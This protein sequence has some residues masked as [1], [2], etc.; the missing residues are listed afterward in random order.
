MKTNRTY[1][2][3]SQYALWK[4][5][6]KGFYKKYSQ[7]NSVPSTKFQDFGKKFMEDLEFGRPIDLPQ[8]SL[9]RLD[10]LSEVEAELTT[11]S[12]FSLLGII[13][14]LSSNGTEFR[15]YKTGKERWT[16]LQVRRDEQTL[17]YAYLIYKNFNV[18]PT[19][20]LIWIETAQTDEEEIFF[21]GN[22]TTFERTFTLEEI[23]EMEESIRIVLCE[24]EE[25]EHIEL[26]IDQDVT[27]KLARLVELQ[28]KTDKEITLIKEDILSDLKSKGLKYGDGGFGTYT[29]SIRKSYIFSDQI[30]DIEDNHK[31]I[32]S[33][34]KS[35]EIK[36][37]IAI[38]KETHSLLFKPKKF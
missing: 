28:K 21:T 18:I 22:I 38:P 31:A 1:L 14:S 30:I 20:K 25:Y 24:I 23:L 6:Q 10:V 29:I 7:N 26:D 35:E 37:G 17:F 13:D 3:Y 36:K 5:S 27:K 2:S 15:E 33:V 9:E 11:F 32:L 34:S 19:A 4:S 8:E 12:P 16:K